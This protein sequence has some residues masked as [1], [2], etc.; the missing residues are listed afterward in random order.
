MM[1][2][3]G[4]DI[5]HSISNLVL[6]SHAM[7]PGGVLLIPGLGG[8]LG[9]IGPHA[10]ERACVEHMSHRP[11]LLVLATPRISSRIERLAEIERPEIEGGMVHSLSSN[12]VLLQHGYIYTILSRPII[13]LAAQARI[14]DPPAN[15]DR[16]IIISHDCNNALRSLIGLE[17]KPHSA[18][19]DA[20]TSYA[21]LDATW[22]AGAHTTD[23]P[24]CDPGSRI[25]YYGLAYAGR[26]K[27]YKL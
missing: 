2:V 26:P 24:I 21:H 8:I 18:L 13:S 16:P 15:L 4:T 17:P 7:P 14:P 27:L 10:L 12:I 6:M 23:G 3:A 5:A 19:D 20:P 11:W 25:T 22:L 9:P 1:L